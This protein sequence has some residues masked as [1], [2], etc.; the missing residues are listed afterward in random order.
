MVRKHVPQIE[1]DPE[2]WTDWTV[3]SFGMPFYLW[4]V[5]KSC[6][7][8]DGCNPINSVTNHLSTGDLDFATIHPMVRSTENSCVFSAVGMPSQKSRHSETGVWEKLWNWNDLK[9]LSQSF[10]EV[11]A[12]F[13]CSNHQRGYFSFNLPL[14]RKIFGNFSIPIQ[15]S[16][17][18]YSNVFSHFFLFFWMPPCQRVNLS[19][20]QLGRSQISWSASR[21]LSNSR[22]LLKVFWSRYGTDDSCC[23]SG[24]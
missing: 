8:L 11:A 3:G 13:E 16:R 10:K 22:C 19:T 1:S 6:T 24:I 7:T 2:D 5:A 12:V 20:C 18:R 17:R 14:Y 9:W 15:I 23:I 4:M 21:V